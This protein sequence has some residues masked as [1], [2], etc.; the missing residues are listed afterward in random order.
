MVYRLPIPSLTADDTDQDKDDKTKMNSKGVW[1]VS[2]AC[3]VFLPLI[4]TTAVLIG[5]YYGFSPVLS[6]I[7]LVCVIA[8]VFI[9]SITIMELLGCLLIYL[10]LRKVKSP[11]VYTISSHFKKRY[12]A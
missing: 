6:Q 3:I 8:L 10:I 12:A 9:G 11:T 1:L 7:D 4:C 2:L 5:A